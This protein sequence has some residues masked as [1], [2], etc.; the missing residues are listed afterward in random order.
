L[1]GKVRWRWKDPTPSAVQAL[2]PKTKVLPQ[3]KAIVGLMKIEVVEFA[4]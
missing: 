3:L 4:M 2:E 1:G